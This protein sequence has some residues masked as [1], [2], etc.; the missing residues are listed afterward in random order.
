MGALFVEVKVAFPT[1]NPCC[2]NNTLHR[3]G[4]CPTLV[5]LVL[6]Y[7]TGRSTT[8]AL[9]DFESGPKPLSI[10]LPQGSPLSGILYILDNTSLLTQVSEMSDTSSLGFIDNVSFITA[11]ES[12]N[13]V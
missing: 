5:N 2:L 4:L 7:L 6:S 8:I 1:V 13:K 9:D 10:G 11:D 12:L 3:Q